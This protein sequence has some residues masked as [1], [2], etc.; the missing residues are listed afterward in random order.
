[1]TTLLKINLQALFAG[2]FMK[3]RSGKKRSPVVTVLIALLAVYVIV[4]LYGMFGFMTWQLIG[5]IF[6]AGNGWFY[7]F[8][9][10]MAAFAF[11]FIG[12]VFAAQ[13]QI[14][15]AKDNDLLLSM[16]VKPFSILL[17]RV[18]SL[19]I[20]DYIFESFIVLPAGFVWIATQPVS[21]AGVI[22]YIIAILLLPL[23]A[24]AFAMLFAWLLSMATARLRNKNI[25]TLI[26]WLLFFF[27]YMVVF[28]NIQKYIL[29]LIQNGTE[30]AAAVQ[31]ALFPMYHLG[32]A[33]ERGSIVSM[34]IFTICAIAP[35][36]L[37]LLILSVNFIKIATTKRGTAKIKYTQRALKVSGVRAAFVQK[38]LLH[39]LSNPMYILNTAL[40]GLFML[41]GAVALVIKRDAVLN[42]ISQMNTSGLDLSPEVLIC[43]ALTVVAAMNFVSAPS[44][45]LEGKNLWIAKSLPVKTF[46]ILLSKAE[47]HLLVCGIPAA[48]SALI[49]AAVLR[50]TVLQLVLMLIVPLMFTVLTALF[51]VFINLQFPKFDWINEMQPIK[52]GLAPILSM[53]GS[54][55]V[56][57]ALILLYLFILSGLVSAEIYL[58]MC[59]LLF[60]LLSAALIGYFKKGGS[61]RFDALAG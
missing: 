39:F 41:I 59:A 52:Q 8:M 33:V 6:S 1:M 22:F 21:A 50:P 29:L 57:A 12:S 26:L 55:A 40:G 31:R 32:I 49:C 45:S 47:T 3:S 43:V 28:S 9:V 53:F 42:V 17:S 60:T 56:I 7:F 48:V 35:F 46:D 16:P 18:A 51:G 44:I 61:R 4:V 25:I 19:L 54:V 11:C 13:S 23:T 24:I 2:L 38:E 15:N 34:L 14:F 36:V 58:L 10:G 30:I 20:L 27:A 37:A 5:P